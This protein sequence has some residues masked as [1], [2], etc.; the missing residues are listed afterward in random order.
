MGE[1]SPVGNGIEQGRAAFD[2]QAWGRAYE[3]LSAAGEEEPLEVADLERLAAAAYLAGHGE[4]SSDLWARASQ[5]CARIGEVARAARCAFWLAFAL[6][7][8]GEV[9]RGGGWIDRAQRLLDERRLDCVEQ[10]YL[11]YGAALRAVF[12][13]DV[14][15][16]LAG[17]HEA[18]GM[19]ERFQ[20]VELTTLARIGEGRCL[21]Y[22]GEVAAGVSL[23]D[24]AMVAVG[25]DEVSAVAVGDAYCT[26]IDGC[27]ELFDVARARE[28]TAALSRWCD[29]QPELVLYRGQCL[30][31][32][33]EI[34]RL[35][36]SWDEALEEVERAIARLAGPASPRILGAA[37]HVRAEVHRLRGEFASAE[38]AYRESGEHGHQPQPGL[39]LLRRAQG[40]A[41][42]AAAAIRRAEQEADDPLSRASLLGP[43]VEIVLAEGDVDA[44]ERA[45]GELTVIAT[46]LQQP[47]LEAASAH[48]NGMVRL[49][50]GESRAALVALRRGWRGWYGLEAPYEAARSR[51]Q[52]ALACRALGDDDGA[53]MELDAAR[54]A[55]ESLGA[56]PDAATVVSL[57]TSAA[58]RPGGLTAREVE[59][60]ALVATGSTNRQIA[61]QLVISE[62]TVGSHVGHILTKLGLSS[63]SAATAYAYEHGLM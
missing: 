15:H 44:A 11:R 48:A 5:E 51:V 17:F 45:A 12:S 56:I 62:R 34:L 21:I 32:R 38:D 61:D 31:H 53:D 63:R 16:A 26:V 36:G 59:V 43:Y 37:A 39:A 30:V 13:G 40:R 24:E 60:L 50:A 8:G 6:L 4:E 46:E 35:R 9:A 47:F 10:G 33:A 18:G 58:A 3:Q 23:L 57:T 54:A 20:D 22:A 42:L 55:F 52:I 19:G 1:T 28:W 41:D 29:A 25:A 27:R 2:R 49:A 7:N 14:A